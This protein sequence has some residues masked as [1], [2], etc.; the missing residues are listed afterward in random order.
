MEAVVAQS[1]LYTY[2]VICLEEVMGQRKATVSISGVPGEIRTEHLLSL[3]RRRCLNPPSL[4]FFTFNPIAMDQR[5]V[6]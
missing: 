2:P 4:H 3:E 6:S 5:K 1:R